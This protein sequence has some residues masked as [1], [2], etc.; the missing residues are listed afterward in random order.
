MKGFAG[1]LF[2]PPKNR[3]AGR[4]DTNPENPFILQIPVQTVCVKSLLTH[5]PC[6]YAAPAHCL[7]KDLQDLKD[8]QDCCSAV[9][10]DSQSRKA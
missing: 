5:N 6:R 2:S 9:P 3:N 8:L 7:N 4:L 10:E 1:L